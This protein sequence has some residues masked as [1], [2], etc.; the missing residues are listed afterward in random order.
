MRKWRRIDWVEPNPDMYAVAKSLVPD[1]YGSLEKTT[2]K[3]D[4]VAG[5]NTVTFDLK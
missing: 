4:I 5:E 2:L 1:R 3:A